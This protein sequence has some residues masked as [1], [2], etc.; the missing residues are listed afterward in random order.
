MSHGSGSHPV[1]DPPPGGRGSPYT[2]I[3]ETA[4]ERRLQRGVARLQEEIN[5][6]EGGGEETRTGEWR[7]GEGGGDGGEEGRGEGRK[8]GQGGGDRG[9]EGR[10]QGRG[11]EEKGERRRGERRRGDRGGKSRPK[12]RR[13]NR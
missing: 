10:R 5:R 9:E 3:T 4:E 2:G 8:R 6:E 11:G 12:V 1:Q 7:R 13:G